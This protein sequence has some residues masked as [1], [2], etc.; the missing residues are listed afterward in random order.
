MPTVL[1]LTDRSTR[2]V[3][4]VKIMGL[5][6]HTMP[7]SA[8]RITIKGVDVTPLMVKEMADPTAKSIMK[9]TVLPMQKSI[10]GPDHPLGKESGNS[11]PFIPK[12]I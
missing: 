5:M 9:V 3:A 6:K 11:F 2:L 12:D 1:L 7:S 4:A 8:I 10:N